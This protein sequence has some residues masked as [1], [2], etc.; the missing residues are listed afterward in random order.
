MN[1]N[2]RNENVLH[3][4]V[5][6]MVLMLV[7]A[8]AWANQKQDKP[9]PAPRQNAPVQTSAPSR[10]APPPQRPVQTQP[11]GQGQRPAVG[12]GQRPVG[13]QGQRPV[14]VQGQKPGVGQGQK[15]GVGQ[16]QKPCVG[17]GQ[18]P[19]IGQG[20]KP[21]VGQG[22]KTQLPGKDISLKGGGTANLRLNN[23]IRSIDTK[24][25]MHIE[26][27]LR[28]DR[29]IVT[30]TPSGARIVSMGKQGGY[31]QRAYMKRDGQTYYSRTYYEHGVY[32]TAVYRSYNYGGHY[33]YGYYHPYW[34]HPAFYGWAY[35]PWPGPVYWS[36]GVGG[37]G[38]S[39]EPWYG[40]YGGYFAPYPVYASPAFWLT[41]YVVAANLQ[42]SYA[43][44]H[45]V[46]PEVGTEQRTD[47]GQPVSQLSPQTAPTGQVALTD[48]VKQAIAEEVKEQMKAA[49]TVA[50][51]NRSAGGSPA[52]APAN[53]DVPPA[54]NPAHRTFIVSTDLAVVADGQECSLT[55]GDV[56]TRITD[57]PDQEQKVNVSVASS[58][59][60]DCSAGKMVAV[61]VDDLQEMHNH[62]QEQIDAGLKVLAAKQGTGSFPKAPDTTLVASD[63]PPAPPDTTAG[64]T[65]EDQGKAADQTE[66]EVR[67]ASS[68]MGN[69]H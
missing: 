7:S 54:L 13:V 21:S 69:S 32:R 39:A 20:Q 57:T 48:D 66:A 36:V 51:Q 63:V 24:N 6:V 5:L 31:V 42:A 44:A 53:S 22:G 34:Y 10:P 8:A 62:F 37:W 58:K 68:S 59:K 16:G 29:R 40:Y 15:P 38:W 26:H 25:G 11:S 61:S 35:N 49:E 23:Q 45:S 41:D 1:S 33:Y 19:C 67:L 47:G 55:P 12:Q 9:A 50:A 46:A 43:E 2:K 3:T 14:G 30:T 52:S 17:Q 27:N 4:S 65:L 56:I 64:K 28:G 18:K 60:T